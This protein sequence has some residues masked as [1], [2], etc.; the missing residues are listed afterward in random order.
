MFMNGRN[1]IDGMNRGLMVIYVLLLVAT[2]FFGPDEEGLG[3]VNIALNVGMWVI[4]IIIFVRAM[5]KNLTKRREESE[6][7]ST[8]WWRFRTGNAT[9]ASPYKSVYI[10]CDNC[11]TTCRVPAGKGKIVVICPKCQLE[12]HTE[13]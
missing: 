7:W 11:G 4:L 12:I 8:F 3:W 5:S 6:K 13:T 1:G 10:T 2:M 9:G